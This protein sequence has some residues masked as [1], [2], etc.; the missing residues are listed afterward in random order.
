MAYDIAMDKAIEE[1]AK[2]RPYVAAAKS[3]TDFNADRFSVQFFNRTLHLSYPEGDIEEVGASVAPLQWLHVLLLHYLVQ[4]DGTPVADKWISYRQLPGATLFEARFMNMSI[5]P[6]TKA[7]GND[8]EGFKR[9]AVALGGLPITRTG[10][11]AFRF[12]ALPNLPIACILYL[13]DEEVQPSVNVLFDAS[14]S[15]YLPTEDLSLLG[16]YLNAMQ[17]YKTPT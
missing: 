1:F 9:G 3:G 16:S 4:A 10:D 17:R 6:L 5:L 7:F 11:A 2:L 8:M 15:S 14:A 13:G 12:F